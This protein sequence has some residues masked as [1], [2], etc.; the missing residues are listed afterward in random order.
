M[1]RNLPMWSMIT[2]NF[3]GEGIFRSSIPTLA[4]SLNSDPSAVGMSIAASKL[5]WLFS[6]VLVGFAIDHI[7]SKKIVLSGSLIRLTSFSILIAS[8]LLESLTFPEFIILSTIITIGDISAELAIHT[9][10]PK[11]SPIHDLKKINSLFLGMQTAFSQLTA[12]I[13]AGIALI[14]GPNTLISSLIAIQVGIILIHHHPKND[15]SINKKS[16]IT[17][18]Q[19]VIE[20]LKDR[21][22]FGTLL[23]ASIMMTSYGAWSSAFALYVF[24]SASGLGL[25]TFG[26]G[27]MMSSIALGSLTGTILWAKL[28][29]NLPHFPLICASILAMTVLPL[30]GLIGGSPM[31]VS[32]ALFIYG[33]S[34]AIW[35]VISITYRQRFVPEGVLGRITGIYRSVTWGFMPLGAVLGS[36]IC[37]LESYRVT[38]ALAAALSLLQLISLPLLRDIGRVHVKRLSP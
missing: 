25:T 13:V 37:T 27:L 24:D 8:I 19:K 29:S 38:L 16:T 35:N 17:Q 23:A 30:G 14:G 5:P 4:I 9:S 26:Y 2:L 7:S 3:L 28:I 21:T 32:L 22:L 20:P 12:P 1:S 6:P 10:I 18:P 11:I 15:Q 34:L 31:F 33:F 36:V